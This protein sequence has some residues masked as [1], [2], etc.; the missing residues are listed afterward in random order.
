MIIEIP[1]PS[2]CLTANERRV[3]DLKKLGYTDRQ[4]AD[5]LKMTLGNGSRLDNTRTQS[6]FEAISEIRRKGYKI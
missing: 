3:L 2:T 1:K 4:V 5:E 6:V